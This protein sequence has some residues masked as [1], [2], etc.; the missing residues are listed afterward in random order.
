M[1]NYSCAS[2]GSGY[3]RV[4][5]FTAPNSGQATADLDC[6]DWND[7]YDVFIL[8][9]ACHPN[10]CIAYGAS[11]SCDTV[12]FQVTAGMSYWIVV[13]EY[14]NPWDDFRVTLTCP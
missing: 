6:I 2:Y 10:L 4:Y 7:D 5:T 9:G 12:N 3:D 14:M 8:E 1:N 11:S 13:E